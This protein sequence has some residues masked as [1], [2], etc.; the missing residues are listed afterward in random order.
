MIFWWIC[1]AGNSEIYL[2][3][4]EKC[5]IF[6]SN[7]NHIWSSSTDNYKA[8]KIKFHGNPSSGSCAD[9]RTDMMKATDAFRDCA[10]PPNKALYE[11]LNFPNRKFL[12]R[13][14][15]LWWDWNWKI[16][17]C[18]NFTGGGRKFFKIQHISLKGYCAVRFI[19]VF[20][21][22]AVLSNKSQK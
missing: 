3:L 4:H 10:N 16:T 1:V 8:S 7:F 14:R 21:G 18:V 6:L 12:K 22:P 20:L 9:T 17:C 11:I 5:P 15:F 2:G 19:W 13:N